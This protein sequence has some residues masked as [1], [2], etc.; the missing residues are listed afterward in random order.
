MKII[1]DINRMQINNYKME[2]V[3]EK[4]SVLVDLFVYNKANFA[5]SDV[6]LFINNFWAH[7]TPLF[8]E[9]VFKLYQEAE[10]YFSDILN[11]DDLTERLKDVASRLYKMHSYSV[12]KDWVIR[13]S[14]IRVPPESFDE[15]YKEDVDRKTTLDKTYLRHEYT[16]LVTLSLML[17][18]MVPIWSRY[19]K[20]I[21]QQSGTQFKE[22]A[23]FKL[24][25][26]TDIPTLPPVEKLVRY[27][28]A[29]LKKDQNNSIADWISEDDYPYFFMSC[30]CVRKLC[31]GDI[32]HK[33]PKANLV[34]LIH[35]FITA[36]SG[37][38]EGDFANAVLSK[39]T[40][41]SGNDDN[42]ISVMEA[43]R[44]SMDISIEES[45]ELPFSVENVRDVVEKVCI[46]L[47]EDL[48]LECLQSSQVLLEIPTMVP[49]KFLLRAI[50]KNAI[51]PAG[52]DYLPPEIMVNCLAITQAVLWHRGFK[53]LSL[54]STAVCPAE[55]DFGHRATVGP[56]KERVSPQL[57][58]ELRKVFPHVRIIQH[59]KTESKEDCKVTN[60]IE[61]VVNELYNSSWH[62]TASMRMFKEVFGE[63]VYTTNIKL[64]PDIR[65]LLTEFIIAV[66]TNKIANPN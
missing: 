62:A 20:H 38:P 56:T 43:F 7:Q 65:T 33:D 66:G 54:L 2:I 8:Q 57:Q 58:A 24:L 6:F 12:M 32:S 44:V 52:I 42:K 50:M 45:Q 17:R 5:S 18:L 55:V 48:L 30:V 23:S 10:E 47:P 11:K 64:R 49:Q 39:K 3:H 51:S 28:H 63:N 40:D 26:R 1:A 35:N 13:Y 21:R 36:Q 46:D 59:R 27:I 22:L 4:E 9:T 60:D 61:M 37:Y 19:T 15:K 31:V 41:D 25:E 29:K 34:T 14:Q 16:E 53:Y